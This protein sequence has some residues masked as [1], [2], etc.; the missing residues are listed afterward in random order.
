MASCQLTRTFCPLISSAMRE[1]ETPKPAAATASSRRA[2]TVAEMTLTRCS[3]SLSS[4]RNFLYFYRGRPDL[5]QVGKD[6]RDH[7]LVS[8]HLGSLVSKDNVSQDIPAGHTHVKLPEHRG[9]PHRNN[10]CPR[11]QEGPQWQNP[12]HHK[13]RHN[14]GNTHPFGILKAP[15]ALHSNLCM[16]LTR[17]YRP[18]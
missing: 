8:N 17:Q 14:I 2:E 3:F 6:K 18:H 11:L 16:V 7:G 15:E 10:V 12:V 9:D 13:N 4:V 5:C 1:R